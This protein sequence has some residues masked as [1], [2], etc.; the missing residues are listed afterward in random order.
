MI[1]SAA[2]EN[3]REKSVFFFFLALSTNFSVRRTCA[4][5]IRRMAYG[6]HNFVNVSSDSVLQ[7]V[8]TRPIIG[9][10]YVPIQIPQ[11]SSHTRCEITDIWG[12]VAYRQSD[13][14]VAK[15]KFQLGV[16]SHVK[17]NVVHTVQMEAAF[18]L[19]IRY[20]IFYKFVKHEHQ[21]CSRSVSVWEKTGHNDIVTEH[22]TMSVVF[23]RDRDFE[24]LKL[25]IL[26]INFNIHPPKVVSSRTIVDLAL[27][28]ATSY[29]GNV[30]YFDS[31]LFIPI[32]KF[33]I[34][35][36]VKRTS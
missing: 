20:F 21:V 13:L 36:D 1:V 22:R 12:A 6:I 16:A 26:F 9:A 32:G 34:F 5:N 25:P 24:S 4:V 30:V 19:L 33:H 23:S 18:S 2:Y 31:G 14:S 8:G 10:R 3:L 17:Q 35:L 15:Q 27:S 28:G 7:V 29:F 11:P